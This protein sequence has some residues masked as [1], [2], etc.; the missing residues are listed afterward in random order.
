MMVKYIQKGESLD[1]L[2]LTDKKITAGEVVGLVTRIGV[3]G[4]DIAPGEVG[5]VEV[6]GVFEMAKSGKSALP[7][8]TALYFDGTGI[9]DETERTAEAADGQEDAEDSG[10]K[11]ANI[12]AGYAAAPASADAKTVMVKLLG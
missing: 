2:N 4:C 3:A 6:T 11:T 8:G 12:P 10:G 1:Y 5:S 9:T 7:M